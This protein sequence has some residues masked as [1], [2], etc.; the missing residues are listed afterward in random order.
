MGTAGWVKLHETRHT[1]LKKC[2]QFFVC[3]NDIRHLRN[4]RFHRNTDLRIVC[5]CVAQELGPFRFLCGFTGKKGHAAVFF[6]GS[7]LDHRFQTFESAGPC[8]V[9]K[10][11]FLTVLCE[12]DDYQLFQNFSK[13]ERRAIP[14]LPKHVLQFIHFL[15]TI[16]LQFFLQFRRKQFSPQFNNLLALC[17]NTGR[18]SP[19]YRSDYPELALRTI[20]FD[21]AKYVPLLSETCR[22][23]SLLDIGLSK[24][25]SAISFCMIANREPG[26]NSIPAARDCGV[27]PGI[28]CLLFAVYDFGSLS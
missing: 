7:D 24:R 14:V 3:C 6:A 8:S 21:R 18:V 19:G 17:D 13:K 15:L 20:K 11:R 1:R 10:K 26:S 23:I 25:P 9:F 27:S 5:C 16:G 12:C 4:N 2:G 28:R 22:A